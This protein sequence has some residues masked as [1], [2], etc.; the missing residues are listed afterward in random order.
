MD[1]KGLGKPT[2]ASYTSDVCHLGPPPIETGQ[3]SAAA[4]VSLGYIRSPIWL[5]HPGFSVVRQR[6]VEPTDGQTDG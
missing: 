1:A 6:T 5:E 2:R 3:R 4:T